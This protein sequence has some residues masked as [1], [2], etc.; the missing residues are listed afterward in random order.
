MF[1][2][3]LAVLAPFSLYERVEIPSMI[4]LG[5]GRVETCQ[6][7]PDITCGGYWLVRVKLAAGGTVALPAPK[8]RR[9]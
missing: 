7:T 8:L 4:H 1:A 9:A 2:P 3:A 5:K 6:W